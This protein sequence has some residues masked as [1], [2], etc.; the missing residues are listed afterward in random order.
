MSVTTRRLAYAGV[1]TLAA[2]AMSRAA[3]FRFQQNEQVFRQT[4]P[5][6]LQKLGITRDAAKSKYPTPEIQMVSSGCL[7]PGATGE[8]VVKGKFAPDTKFIFGNDNLEVVKESLAG[9][10]YRAMV[11]V[12][13]GI[14]PQTAEV[15]AI[16]PATCITARRSGAVVIGGRYE[17]KM[18]SAN[19]WTI[20]AR[21]PAGK[22][23]GGPSGD[24]VYAMEF[25]RKGENA[26]FEKREAKLYFSLY[27]GVSRFDIARAVQMPGGMEDFQSLMKKMAD[28]NL[29]GAER[30]QL[31]KQLEKAQEQMQAGMKQMT[32]PSF[33]KSVEEQWK[34]FGCERMELSV[35]AGA[36]TGRMRCA[37]G[38]GV[39]IALTGSLKFLGR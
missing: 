10:E 31:M 6:Q 34:K 27:E 25:F 1:L 5:V 32:D 9:N 39:N 23:C 18:E 33:A 15:I 7:T 24:D 11:K 17:W 3:Q 37:Q 16:T 4:C 28:P 29:S 35:Q 21:S 38:V 20:V 2:L 26:A 36:L 8:V 13:P 12:A 22:A 30:D 14:G 19:G